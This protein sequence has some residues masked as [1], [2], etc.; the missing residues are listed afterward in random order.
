MPKGHGTMCAST[1]TAHPPRHFVA[2]LPLRGRIWAATR[3]E[4]KGTLMKKFLILLMIIVSTDSFATGMGNVSSAPCDNDTLNKY[5]GTANVEINWEPNTINL[6][7]YDGDTKLTVANN[8]QTCVYDG[9]LTVPTQPTK[10]GYTFNGWKVIRVPG[11]FTEL[12]YIES[13]GTQWIDTGIKGHMNYI[14]EIDFQQTDTGDYRRW[15]VF[16]QS[17]YVGLNMSFTWGNFMVRWESV[18]GL[19]RYVSLARTDTDRHLLKIDNG[20]IYW[21]GVS[22][23]R[24]KGHN[25]NTVINY[26]LFLGTANPAGHAPSTNAHS[27]YYSYKVWD[28]N[29]NLIQ[30]FIPARRNSDNV[31]GMYDSITNQ[32]FTNAGTGA[33]IAGPAVQ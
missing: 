4:E 29:G 25:S 14:Y 27:K 16:G 15:G 22:K 30:N 10:P 13:T 20:N 19:D 5:T 17:D 23:G 18:N 11:G 9:T 31:V 26:N 3:T 32:F 28:N 21:D 7:W 2:H 33:F 8:S 12:Q 6:N 24:S 1:I